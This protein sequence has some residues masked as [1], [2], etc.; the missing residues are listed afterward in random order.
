[1]VIM[2]GEL[3]KSLFKM[4]GNTVTG[5]RGVVP[6]QLKKSV[7]VELMKIRKMVQQIFPRRYLTVDGN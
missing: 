6:K 4:V 3:V 5:G 2:K 7:E 1:M